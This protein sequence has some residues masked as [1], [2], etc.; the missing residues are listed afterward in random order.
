MPLHCLIARR[1]KIQCLQ[2]AK[3]KPESIGSAVNTEYSGTQPPADVA[4]W[5]NA[6]SLSVKSTKNKLN[7]LSKLRV[8]KIFAESLM[9]MDDRQIACLRPLIVTTPRFIA[10]QSDGQNRKGAYVNGQYETRGFFR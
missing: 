7:I 8:Q 6:L 9:G 2:P 3:N 4:R 5:E 1:S 10:F